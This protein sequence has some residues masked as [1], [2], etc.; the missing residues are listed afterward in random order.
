MTDGDPVDRLSA[1]R[2]F[3]LVLR[4]IVQAHGKVTGELVDPLTLQR[5]RFTEFGHIVN[6]VHNWIDDARSTADTRASKPK[7]K[8]TET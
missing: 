5:Q 6:A 8:P 1:R 3:V 2:H 4:L 7:E